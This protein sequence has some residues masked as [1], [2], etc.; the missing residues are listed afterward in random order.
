MLFLLL[1][2]TQYQIGDGGVLVLRMDIERGWRMDDAW[3]ME[4]DLKV[5]KQQ[6][7]VELLER[8]DPTP[9]ARGCG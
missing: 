8:G 7:R 2:M 3:K 9:H 4:M 6:I 5:T 1:S